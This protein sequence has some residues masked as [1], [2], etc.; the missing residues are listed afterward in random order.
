MVVSVCVISVQESLF[1]DMWQSNP[2]VASPH[3]SQDSQRQ[4]RRSASVLLSDE[5]ENAA[6]ALQQNITQHRRWGQWGQFR[7]LTGPPQIQD[8]TFTALITRRY[9]KKALICLYFFSGLSAGTAEKVLQV[10]D[11]D[12]HCLSST[13]LWNLP[14]SCKSRNLAS[15][16]DW[17]GSPHSS[18]G[19]V[20]F[21]IAKAGRR[22][23][24]ARQMSTYLCPPAMTQAESLKHC[25]HWEWWRV[26]LDLMSPCPSATVANP[27][28]LIDFPSILSFRTFL[29]ADAFQHLNLR[30][31]CGTCLA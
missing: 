9:W 20:L 11:H 18:C 6:I 7:P 12:S 26:L 3:P 30:W 2:L 13:L 22:I 28:V 24:G 1:Q 5:L 8:F 31:E 27:L 29:D 16:S 23:D 25:G 4:T 17:I 21:Y 10:S 19:E 14:Q 15:N